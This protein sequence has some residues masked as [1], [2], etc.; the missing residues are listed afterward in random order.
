MGAYRSR[1]YLWAMAKAFSREKIG[2]IIEDFEDLVDTDSVAVIQGTLRSIRIIELRPMS[3]ASWAERK[4]LVLP[5]DIDP[6]RELTIP[7]I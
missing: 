3:L 1:V 7:W 2:E 5:A 6:D 4:G